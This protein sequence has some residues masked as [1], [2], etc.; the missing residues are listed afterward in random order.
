MS[1]KKKNGFTAK[2]KR[3]IMNACEDAARRGWHMLNADNAEAHVTM[4]PMMAVTSTK[5][6]RYREDAAKALGCNK[7]AINDF[8]A[9]YDGWRRA[10]SS[11][12]GQFGAEVFRWVAG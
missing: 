9:G 5:G 3:M 10:L 7:Q 1:A 4:R 2:Q 11:P 8:I 12:A 6:A